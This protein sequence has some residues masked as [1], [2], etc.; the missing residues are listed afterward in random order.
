MDKHAKIDAIQRLAKSIVE[1]SNEFG[2]EPAGSQL[3]IGALALA[4]GGFIGHAVKPEALE[5]VL[6]DFVT[7]VTVLAS[8]ASRS[9]EVSLGKETRQ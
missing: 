3:F 7:N 9:A 5:S 1:L 8:D 2:G 4:S 6:K